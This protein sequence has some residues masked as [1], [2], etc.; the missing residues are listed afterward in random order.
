MRRDRRARHQIDRL[1]VARTA[2]LLAGVL[3]M[4]ACTT[5]APKKTGPALQATA[6]RVP[7]AV[8]YRGEISAAARRYAVPP[9]L[10]LAIIHAESNFDPHAVSHKGAV[11]L[12]QLMP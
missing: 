6:V 1:A 5:A 9:A 4:S 10:L 12:M 11:G 8:P 3:V 2:A 7:H